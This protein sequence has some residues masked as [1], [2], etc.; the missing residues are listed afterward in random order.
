MP[1]Q[2]VFDFPVRPALGREDFVVTPAND[3]ALAALDTWPDWPMP[4]FVLT[5]PKGA[6]KSHLAAVFADDHGAATTA[7]Q[8]VPNVND[9]PLVLEWDGE[10]FDEEALFHLLNRRKA[11]NA[12]L[13]ICARTAPKRW[14]VSLPDLRSR[15]ATF[16]VLEIGLPDDALLGALFL[17]H[18]ADKQLQ[19]DSGVVDFLTKR[20]K[21]SFDAVATVAKKLDELSLHEARAITIPLARKALEG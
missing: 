3:M 7:L 16:G 5:G 1:D 17:K 9:G 15:L 19:V 2:L 13:L 4:G 10:A 12:P 21:R 8:N 20:V 18:F 11:N 14:P 6:G